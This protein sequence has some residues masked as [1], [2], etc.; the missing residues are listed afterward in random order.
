ML[1]NV[2][3]GLEPSKMARAAS[4]RNQEA[5]AEVDTHVYA[6]DMK[7][8]LLLNYTLPRRPIGPHPLTLI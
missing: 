5:V 1:K 8:Y 3:Q 2:G 7:L 6:Y 4:G